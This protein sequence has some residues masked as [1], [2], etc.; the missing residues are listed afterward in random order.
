M[1]PQ[2]LFIQL[3]RLGDL[4][5]S[6][7]AFSALTQTFHEYAFDVLCPSP[8]VPLAAQFPDVNRVFPWKG[9]DWVKVV[10][11]GRSSFADQW[12]LGQRY[13][14]EQRF[15]S[16][17]VAYN[18]NNHP[19]GILLAH[20]LG[21]RVVGPGQYGPLHPSMP[22]WPQYLSDVAV[23]RGDNRIHLADAFCGLCGVQ[24]PSHVPRLRPMDQMVPEDLG[25]E[26]EHSSLMNLA[27]VLGAGDRERKVPVHVWGQLIERIVNDI[28]DSQIILIGGSGEREI[29]LAVENQ[30]S[31]TSLGRVVN[32]CGRTTLE[33]LPALLSHCDWVVGSDTG[34]LHLGV[35]AG[36]KGIG[37]YF[38]R[39]RVHETGPYG[40]GHY[41]YQF[42]QRHSSVSEMPD[43]DSSRGHFPENWPIADTVQLMRKGRRVSETPG[44]TLWESQRDEWGVYYQSTGN[45][46]GDILA[47]KHVWDRLAPQV[48]GASSSPVMVSR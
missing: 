12:L 1:R 3:A 46:E 44:W 35:L 11:R 16:Y 32:A 18:L 25:K 22:A 42:E 26:L 20:L 14:E 5:Q 47:R 8:L 13:W 36:V 23:N 2:A 10:R 33:Q 34:P 27:I 41:V 7:P 15:S 9:P 48:D 17:T 39:A 6:L 45:R 37:W 29:S 38:S 4:V 28:P 24:P 19:R 40:V 21:Q 30:L 43:M 31:P